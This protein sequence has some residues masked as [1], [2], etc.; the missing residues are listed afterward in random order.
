MSTL[1]ERAHALHV[2]R[3]P[4]GDLG[5]IG[6][7]D[8]LRIYRQ[9]VR[10]AIEKVLNEKF[11][12]GPD[13][14]TASRVII[15][16]RGSEIVPIILDPVDLQLFLRHHEYAVSTAFAT[17]RSRFAQLGLEV[18]EYGPLYIAKTI[19]KL[20]DS[21]LYRAEVPVHNYAARPILLPEGTKFFYMYYWNKQTLTGKDLVDYMK[22]DI[23]ISGKEGEDWRFW[24]GSH[25]AKTEKNIEGIEFF[26]NE[27]TIAYIPPS[28]E[29]MSI[30]D[31]PAVDHNRASVDAY[32]QK[33]VPDS[34]SPLLWIAE[35]KSRLTLSKNVHGIVDMRV[36]H[37]ENIVGTELTQGFQTNSIL[38]RAGNT[39]SH[40]RTE[41]YSSTKSGIR[42]RIYLIRFAKAQ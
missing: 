30:S 6:T 32:L 27:D 17:T 34:V 22:D 4:N 20:P 39:D 13:I 9:E 21:D 24:Y 33:P 40:I 35:I 15:P 1:A 10:G 26:I 29:A 19:E 38:L 23:R 12:I 3:S 28:D 2:F 37:G 31:G 25:A 41:V 18:D 11:W 42:P 36:S 5:G 8:P 16:A 7:A 14:P